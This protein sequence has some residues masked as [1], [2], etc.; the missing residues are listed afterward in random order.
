MARADFLKRHKVTLASAS[1]LALATSLLVVYAVTADGYRRHDAELNDGG[2]WVVNG[3]AGMHGRMNKPISQIDGVVRDERE[4]LDLDVVQD[5][6]AVLTINRGSRSGRAVDA[7]HLQFG[8]GGAVSLPA[9]GQVGMN[10]GVAASVDPRSG[11]LWAVPVD[12]VEGRAQ[13]AGLDKGSEPVAEAGAG[14]VMAVSEAGT[15]V[16]VSAEEERV[17]RVDGGTGGIG[18]AVRSALPASAGAVDGVTTV[19]ETVVTLDSA[20][21]QLQVLD[22]PD[23]RVPAGSVLQQAGQSSG[24]VLL[25]TPDALVAVDLA[26]GEVVTVAE[27]ASGQPVAP[28]RLGAC[29]YAAWS[30]GSAAVAVACGSE[31]RVSE[32]GGDA[33]ALT[34]R[35]N[36]GQVVLN[37]LP[38]GTVWDVDQDS[39][40]T[41][42]N[43]DAFTAKKQ[44]NDE[45]DKDN[46]QAKGDRRPPKAVDDQYGVRP[47]RT[48]V[49]HPLDNDSAPDGRLLSIVG[50][51][52][53]GRGAT[54]TISPDG[55]TLQLDAPRDMT[56][57]SF[58]YYVNDGRK[59]TA[60][61]VVT[62]RGRRDSQNESP[63]LR[64]AYEDRTWQV[65]A[66]GS[67]SVPVLSDWRDDADGDPLVLEDAST[68]VSG[69][70]AGVRTTADGRV[71]FN[72]PLEGG[73][74]ARVTYTVGDGRGQ[75][76]EHNL[77][78]SVL[79]AEGGAA[80][81]P[82][83]ESDVA[84]G[85]VGRPIRIKPL[86]NDLPGADP[87]TPDA[88]LEL[89]GE[90]PDVAGA[91]VRTDLLK[92]EITV[93][94]D[95]PGVYLLDYDAAYGRAPLGRGKIRVDV[96]PAPKQPQ[97]PVLMPD[98]VTLYGQAPAAVDLLANDVDPAGGV[99]VVQEV[100]GPADG[101]MDLAV[102][103]GRWLRVSTQAPVFNP[104]P[105]VVSYTVSNGTHQS[106]GEVVVSHRPEPEDNAPVTTPDR[107]TV[108][109]GQA[110]TVAPLDNDL[111]P[112]GDQLS[113]VDDE[114]G[115]VGEYRVTGSDHLKGGKGRAFVSGK[116]V[117]YVAPAEVGDGAEYTVQYVA[118]NS[119]GD[120]TMGTV[121]VVVVPEGRENRRPTPPTIEGRAVAND[122]ITLRLP[123][124]GMDPDGDAVTLTGITSA[125]RFGRILSWT[126]SSLEYQAYPTSAGTDEFTY[127]VT[128]TRGASAEGTARIAVVPP[129]APQPPLAV[130][131]VLTVAPGRTGTFDPLANDHVAPGEE[132]RVELVDAPDG[133][134][135]DEE[136]GLVRVPAPD[137]VSAPVHVV[138]ELSNGLQQ[139]RAT[140]TLRTLKDAE[141]APVVRDAFG[142]ADDSDS[143]E[144]DVLLGAY[145]PDGDPGDLE[146]AETYGDPE[147]V[148][149]RGSLVRV[150]RGPEPRVVPFRVEDAHGS[151]AM[152]SLYVPATGTG[153]PY[154]KPDALVE[155][156]SGG[157]ATVTL[158]DVVAS[159]DGGTPRLTRP[160]AVSGSPTPVRVTWKDEN[161]FVVQAQGRY[162]G[163]GAALVEV[164]TALDE[165]GNED[166]DDPSDGATALLSVP[167]QVGDDTPELSCPTTPIDL[168]PGQELDLDLR[169]YCDVWTLD[170]RDRDT[171]AYTAEWE[172]T[173]SDVTIGALSGPV[174]PVSVS[175]Q[176]S[177]G[178]TARLRV[179]AGD[180]NTQTITFRM[181]Q[182]PAPR[183][184]AV[185]KQEVLGG[186]PTTVD[187]DPYLV[188]GVASPTAR[189]VSV[190]QI[191]GT[192]VKA[193]TDGTRVT[194]TAGKEVDGRATFS[195]VMTDQAG[196]ESPA[197]RAEGTIQV[198]AVGVP[199]KP[200]QPIE[201][202]KTSE[203]L[204]LFWGPARDDGGSPVLRY[205]LN[206]IYKNKT[207]RCQSV[208]CQ[209]YAVKPGDKYKFRVRAVNR[210]GAS[211]WSELSVDATIE[212]R[213]LPVRN[214]RMQGRGDGTVTLAWDRPDTP[215]EVRGYR[216]NGTGPLLQSTQFT[217]H[218]QSNDRVETVSV[219]AV[220]FHSP[221]VPAEI[222]VQSLGTPSAPGAPSVTESGATDTSTSATVS[223]GAVSPNG[224]GP[225]EYSVQ[226]RKGIDGWT[227]LNACQRITTTR[228]SHAGLRLDGARYHY[229]VRA[230]NIGDSSTRRVGHYSSWSDST[231]FEAVGTPAAWG[232]W[233]IKPTGS[234]QEAE[235]SYTVPE[236]RGQSSYVHAQ[237]AG[238]NK[239]RVPSAT[240]ART[241]T[242]SVP[243]NDRAFDVTLEVCN[244]HGKCSS[245]SSQPVQTYGGLSISRSDISA[246][247]NG[248]AITWRIEAGGNGDPATLN[249]TIREDG[250]AIATGALN[251]GVAR[252]TQSVP[253]TASTWDKDVTIEVEL[254]DTAPARASST[255]SK[256]ATSGKPPPPSVSVSVGAACTDADGGSPKCK[257]DGG[258]QGDACT[259]ANCAR[260]GI[261]VSGFV[262]D[263]KCKITWPWF[264]EQWD[265][266]PATAGSRN[267]FYYRGGDRPGT[268][269]VE[270]WSDLQSG[271]DS[272]AWP[273]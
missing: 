62:V 234:S 85:Q 195:V 137:E 96:Q 205:E 30:G 229:R 249:Y 253:Y 223:W 225:T 264:N 177:T 217:H 245:S 174:V 69:A 166:P 18:K 251:V 66:G 164:T 71:R 200:Y 106:T 246:D 188:P 82:V 42:D 208:M 263:Y 153:L 194:F 273:K 212:T 142:T 175:P 159:P 9:G 51:D 37:D 128:D 139:S 171:L 133:V 68:D 20:S 56:G 154:V 46:E 221:S 190:R 91:K 162:R 167:V 173:H 94:A 161:T 218:T 134:E 228:C 197:R 93:L 75:P 89:G 176:A 36:R 74:P 170:S 11:K 255:A 43:W 235:I 215:D 119:R 227:N 108:R 7:A 130:D 224:P 262:S 165:A 181:A 59:M 202:Q 67:V 33:S 23:V 260:V 196:S 189:V 72:A 151:T 201:W 31:P 115:V 192:P 107:V 183:M 172:Q 6:A 16:A 104:N 268:V 236:S 126:A 58:Q 187:L 211:E 207:Q 113:L 81:A 168:A 55:Q 266:T 129:V 86:A 35:V 250:T 5:G 261:A 21:G 99:L 77:S 105:Q 209:Y 143:A 29:S 259:E 125:P 12:E 138:Y 65:A 121:E 214:L 60:H 198:T 233:T 122:V 136:T 90:L 147:V 257:I 118:A 240:G 220:G 84:R 124:A 87:A 57:A 213:M 160:R 265:E 179:A 95:A 180:S 53:P 50:V 144:A 243:S 193:Q 152:A 184:L 1:A 145:D 32:L 256:R 34:F 110:V 14:A 135:L 132:P 258:Y 101:Q 131:D 178:G 39:P 2:I 150:V 146:L 78:F 239:I 169:V 73:G 252:A 231:S 148:S 100:S 52:Q 158:T 19:G 92:G 237:V 88:D 155:I 182:A 199:Q 248:K 117:R 149:S 156:D 45:N 230:N 271:S 8:D 61:A 219:V 22:G 48:T 98:A 116:M 216:V 254:S 270:C 38:T 4:D 47:G 112:S 70:G 222:Q 102:V 25:T 3:E 54:V 185:P 244:E 242:I 269:G 15:V 41:I 123:G 109:A 210:V 79:P 127:T 76:T 44:K 17:T 24:S 203:N 206:E 13:V 204:I 141:N 26:T 140:L 80:L 83:A 27:G 63:Q 49:L 111:S 10:G 157:S 64:H 103:D 232:A 28:V 186:R 97:A 163:P 191:G 226:V 120:R 247:V 241:A 40:T 114:E 267:G 272:V 238:G